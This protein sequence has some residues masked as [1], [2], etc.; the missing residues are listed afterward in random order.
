MSTKRCSPTPAALV[1]SASGVEE[2]AALRTTD[3]REMLKERDL[4]I[5]I[6]VTHPITGTRWTMIDACQVRRGC[7]GAKA[8]QRRRRR[9]AGD[10]GR[11]RAST[12]VSCRSA[13]SAGARRISSERAIA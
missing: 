11:R 10:A 3:Y 6:I 2:D 4:D 8:D 13:C 1:A 9:G 5:V 7:L 12:S